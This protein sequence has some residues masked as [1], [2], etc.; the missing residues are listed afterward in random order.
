MYQRHLIQT[1]LQE[2]PL[3]HRTTWEAEE[4]LHAAWGMFDSAQGDM[5]VP[6]SVG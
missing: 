5:F 4:L 1:D 3:L 6:D 2:W